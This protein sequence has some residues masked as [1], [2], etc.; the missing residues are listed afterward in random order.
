MFTKPQTIHGLMK[1]SFKTGNLYVANILGNLALAGTGWAVILLKTFCPN[2]I[3][4]E[5]VKLTGE[6]PREGQC[7]SASE[8]GNQQS[9]PEAMRM[10]LY[11]EVEKRTTRELEDM[12]IT[13]RGIFGTYRIYDGNPDRPI[14]VNEEIC[15]KISSKLCDEEEEIFGP[16]IDDNGRIYWQSNRMAF[17][18]METDLEKVGE[19][20]KDAADTI[21][22]VWKAMTG[23]G[24]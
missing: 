11:E 18:Y 5:T 17:A 3:K 24:E 14:V 19:K 7:Y 20:D 4:A 2:E 10:N 21:W 9:F 6:L 22:A 1:Q 13:V 15:Q 8:D 23:Y 16:C 12:L